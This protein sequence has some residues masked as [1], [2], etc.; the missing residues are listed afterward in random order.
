MN[1]TGGPGP[2]RSLFVVPDEVSA[3]GRKVYGIANTLSSALNSTG[4]DVDE[5]LAQG[6]SGAA[7]SEFAEGW[8]DTREGGLRI[9]QALTGMAAK[10]GIGA[11]NYRDGDGDSAG[12]FTELRL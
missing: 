2:E 6:W 11:D 9:V 1:G 3:F 8:R 4:K 12:E 7:A 5:L 10:L